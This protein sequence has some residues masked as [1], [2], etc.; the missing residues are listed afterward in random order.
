MKEKQEKHDKQASTRERRKE[1]LDKEISKYG[2]LWHTEDDLERNID[3]REDQE[4]KEAIPAKIKYKK[5]VLHTRVND[6][7][8]LLLT[9]NRKEYSLQELEGNL[10]AI[11]R[12]INDEKLPVNTSSK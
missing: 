6:K 11:L 5:L 7:K 8:L 2:G 12:N 3:V 1:N 9:A 10:G 4:K